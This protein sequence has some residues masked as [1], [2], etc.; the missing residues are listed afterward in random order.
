M[1]FTWIVI[2][3]LSVLCAI[4]NFAAENYPATIASISAAFNA[5]M[6]CR[7]SAG[8]RKRSSL[9]LDGITKPR[10]SISRIS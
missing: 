1:K 7:L 8:H 6:V 10:A 2:A 5:A 9:S 4:I 3:I